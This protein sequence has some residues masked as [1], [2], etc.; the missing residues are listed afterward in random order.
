M[1]LK[2]VKKKRKLNSTKKKAVV[3]KKKAV[4]RIVKKVRAKIKRLSKPKRGVP[5]IKQQEP[6]GTVIGKV[7]HY[8]P[9]V[10]AAVVLLDGG[11]LS[12]GD[13]I[14]IKGHTTDFKEVV[15]SIQINHTPVKTAN[16]KD[17]IG[18]L[19]KSRVRINDTVYKL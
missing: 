2:K 13:N 9:H 7:T 5:K 15:G 4:R 18:L 10:K 6:V 16:I 1:V 17:E 12:V 3:P 11:S 8:F 19:V 14:C